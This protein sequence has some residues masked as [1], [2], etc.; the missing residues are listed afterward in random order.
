MANKLTAWFVKT[1]PPGRHGDGDGLWLVVASTG[2]KRWAFRFTIARKVSE[3]GLGSTDVVSLAKARELAADARKMVRAGKSPVAAK[4]EQRQAEAERKTFRE[5][6]DEVIQSRASGWRKSSNSE[7]QWRHSLTHHAAALLEKNVDA[8]TTQ[9]IIGVLKD[10][11]V[12][13][14]VTASRVRCRVETVLDAAKAKGLRSGENPAAWKGNIAHWLVKPKT[15]KTHHAA[16]VYAAIPEFVRFLRATPSIQARAIEFLILTAGRRGEVCGARWEEIDLQTN[17]WTVPASRMK[18]GAAHQV[19]LCRR[20]VELLNELALVQ[21]NEFVFPGKISGRHI[22]GTTI[23]K[24]M[25]ATDTGATAHGMRSAFRDF[26]G[27][28]TNY[29]REVAEAALAHV[30]KGVEGAYRRNTALEKRRELMELWG[31]YCDQREGGNVVEM[32]RA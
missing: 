18:N 4:R 31:A 3:A 14:P 11:W 17:T 6:A 27:D 20:A 13:N 2:R 8:I 7:Y 25:A 28:M 29:P 10:L 23:R 22:D 21:C 12:S 26:C 24:F 30:V 1:A 15:E 19:P 16:L 9:D 32:R 5:V